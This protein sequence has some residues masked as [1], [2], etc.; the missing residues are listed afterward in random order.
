MDEILDESPEAFHSWRTTL[1]FPHSFP[2]DIEYPNER[3]D[4]E[5]YFSLM[6]KSR[7]VFHSN[8]T[9]VLISDFLWDLFLVSSSR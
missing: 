7:L 2:Y 9:P 6:E 3:L 4:F 5:R 8:S 1:S